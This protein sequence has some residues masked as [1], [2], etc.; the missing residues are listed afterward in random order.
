[1]AQCLRDEE[2]GCRRCDG[3][4]DFEFT[5]AF[6]PI[7]DVAAGEVFAH[8]AL[9]RGI[10]GEGA[11]DILNRV[12]PHSLYRFDQACRIRALEIAHR[13]GCDRPVSINFLPNAVY[14]PEACIQATLKLAG[15][16]GW[17][18]AQIM[19]EVTETEHVRDRQHLQ[20]IVESYRAMGFLTAI[21]DFGAGYANLEL[22]V[23]MQPD[24]VKADRHLIIDIDRNPR[25]QAIVESLV[26]MGKKL[27]ITLIAEGVETLAEARWLYQRG[28][29]LQQGFLYARP[30]IETLVASPVDIIEQ[31]RAAA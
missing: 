24:V 1:M 13:L 30:Q 12:K 25:R 2:G 26:I 27:G 20:R 19:F 3:E 21:D 7:I 4:L 14:E 6:Q 23:D 8:E 31:V 22:L 5:M 17:P 18:L 11:R 9:V 16:L 28:I 15:E 10:N 29:H